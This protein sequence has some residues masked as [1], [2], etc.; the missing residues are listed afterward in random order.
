MNDRASPKITGLLQK[1]MKKTAESPA[2][3]RDVFEASNSRLTGLGVPVIKQES[4]NCF[5]DMSGIEIFS[6][7]VEFVRILMGRFVEEYEKAN[8]DILINQAVNPTIT[9]ELSRLGITN[10]CVNIRSGTAKFIFTNQDTFQ[11]H[12]RSIFYAV[13]TTQWGGQ[14]FPA[15]YKTLTRQAEHQQA[16]SELPALLFPFHLDAASGSVENGYMVLLEYDSSGKF[17]RLTI[18]NSMDA[19]LNLKRI[20][21]R[22]VANIERQSTFVDIDK[23]AKQ[24]YQGIHR[25]CQNQQDEFAEMP[26]RQPELFDMLITSGLINLKKIIFRWNVETMRRILLN[27]EHGTLVLL[28]KILHLLQDADIIRILSSNNLLE[29]VSGSN[30][31]YFDVSRCGA[32][33]NISLEERRLEISIADFLNRMPTLKDTTTEA[34]SNLAGYRILLIHHA[35]SEIVGF[36]KALDD[37][38]CAQ[39][40]TLFIKYKG[41]VPDNYIEG[42]FTLPDDK[43]KFYSLQRIETSNSVEAGYVLS[44]QYSSINDFKQL[45]AQLLNDRPDFFNAMIRTAAHL[46]FVE[47]QQAK[48]NNQ[49]LIIIEDGGYLAPLINQY[50]LENKTLSEALELF[51]ILPLPVF[52]NELTATGQSAG[53]DFQGFIKNHY[54]GSIEHTRNGFDL[55]QEL[56]GR[57][58]KLAFPALSIAVSIL[59]NTE[60]AR[61]CAVSILNAFETILHSRGLILSSRNFLIL[62]SHGNIGRNLMHQ[63]SFRIKAGSLQGV[64][65]M[66][67]NEA[68]GHAGGIG[69]P[70]VLEYPGMDA[71][72][73]Q[74]LFKLDTFIGVIGKSTI[75]PAQLE[76][77]VLCGA[78]Q[79]LFFISGSTKTVEF[80][81]LS[82][83]LQNLQ[84]SENPVIRQV[85]VKITVTHLKDAQ[86]GVI[87]GNKVRLIFGTTPECNLP[88][89]DLYLLGDL[90]PLNFLYYGVPT[91]LM[92]LIFA[93][94]MRLTL[95]FTSKINAGETLPLKL[96]AIDRNIDEK[97][98]PL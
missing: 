23:I 14:L 25:E 95:G 68:N 65:L 88:F 50:C 12:L 28:S 60:E 31:V 51:N 79:S 9:P 73:D 13:Q 97:A 32:C 72:K 67:G 91:E 93:Q 89:K 49:K 34:A 8:A 15:Y 7:I 98:N 63:L 4:G 92:D 48:A 35:T 29:M 36:I 54:S 78:R 61:E 74:D 87:H 64:D 30:K 84:A 43:F 82:D 33:L 22:V 6:G 3:S 39:V 11:R 1:L 26:A 55:L 47:L 62:G 59:K 38:K 83:W 24:M 52:N 56:N 41:I 2:E 86:T 70:R 21:H 42:L 18:E 53:R 75:K 45:D 77:I 16:P 17:L 94:L 44:N 19:R 69:N 27:K 46:F 58:G 90:M 37:L 40:T 71:L 80:K 57:H 20:S 81:D 76:K 85:P 5:I 96:L 10:I 66:A